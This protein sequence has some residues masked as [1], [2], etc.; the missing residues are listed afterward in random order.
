[1]RARRRRERE[2]EHQGEDERTRGPHGLLVVGACA[3]VLQAALDAWRRS[4]QP[5]PRPKGVRS[6]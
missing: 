1:V 5:P 4:A 3:A 2:R 6:R